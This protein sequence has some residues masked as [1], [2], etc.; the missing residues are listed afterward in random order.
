MICAFLLLNAIAFMTG[1]SSDTTRYRIPAE[2]FLLLLGFFGLNV[3]L[4]KMRDAIL[5]FPFVYDSYQWLVGTPRLRKYIISRYLQLPEN[6]KVLDI[7]CGTGE[8]IDFLPKKI[9]DTGFDHNNDYIESAKKR[10]GD[11]GTFMCKDVNALGELH[12]KDGEYDVVLLI[13]VLHHINDAEVLKTLSS[14]KK[15]LKPGGFVFS[16]DG[17]YLAQQSKMAKYILSKDRGRYVRFNDHYKTLAHSVFSKV[18]IFIEKGLLRIPSDFIAMK[19][20]G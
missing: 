14:A 20:W 15:L 16:T 7:G 8:L 2:P 4:P 5:E 9:A 18:D 19:M 13:G 3:A 10:Y 11:R 1:P 17:A 6:C 12:L